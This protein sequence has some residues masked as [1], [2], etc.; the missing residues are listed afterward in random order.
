MP[1]GTLRE[2]KSGYQRAN[3]I[4]VTKCPENFSKNEMKILTNKINLKS[5]QHIFFSKII[6][7]NQLISKTNSIK[8]SKLSN[9]KVSVV[10]GIVNSKVLIKYL[11]DKRLIVSHIEFSDHY[12]YRDIDLL[13]FKDEIIIT[14]EKDYVNLKNFELKIYIIYQ[15]KLR[16]MVKMI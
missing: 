9:K 4:I 6:Y 10:T 7:S 16:Y 12:N 5:N 8:I 3:A 11:E 13:K 15:L 14:T 1:L 2:C